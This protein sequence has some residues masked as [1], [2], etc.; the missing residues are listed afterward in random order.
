MAI[1]WYHNELMRQNDSIVESEN[2]LKNL[3]RT[4]SKSILWAVYEKYKID[5]ELFGYNFT[6]EV[7]NLAQ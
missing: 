1:P 7:L 2:K 5:Y 4:V 3:Y 6:K